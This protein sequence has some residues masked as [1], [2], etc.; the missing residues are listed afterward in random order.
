[1]TSLA[2]P[3]LT[4]FCTLAVDL[5]GIMPLGDTNAGS[6]RIIPIKGGHVTGPNIKGRILDMGADWQTLFT[7]GVAELDAHYAFETEDGALIEIHNFGFRHG[8]Q[9]IMQQLATGQ[10]V[11]PAQYYMRSAARLQT[12]HPGYTWINKTM[13]VGTGARHAA[14]VQIDLYAVT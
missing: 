10:P 9:E 3:V 1:M 8:P 12:G 4:H 2:L 7:D 14:S 5:S 11:D 6:R 13:F